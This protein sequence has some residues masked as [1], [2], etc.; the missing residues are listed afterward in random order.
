[1]HVH[2][3]YVCMYICKYV[4]MYVCMC[5]RTYILCMYVYVYVHTYVSSFFSVKNVTNKDAGRHQRVSESESCR[6]ASSYPVNGFVMTWRCPSPLQVCVISANGVSSP[7]LT[8]ESFCACLSSL[9]E[10]LWLSGSTQ[11]WCWMRWVQNTEFFS[12][13]PS[14]DHLIL[15]RPGEG[16]GGKKEEWRPTSVKHRRYKLAP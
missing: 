4:C 14:V 10:A 9:K 8:V 11:H 1:M 13:H 12:V 2:T 16:D 15:F 7:G 5:V 6:V 3:C